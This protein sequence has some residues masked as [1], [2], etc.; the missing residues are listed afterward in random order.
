MATSWSHPL[1]DHAWIPLRGRGEQVDGWCAY[2]NLSAAESLDIEQKLSAAM[3][4]SLG[5]TTP[6]SGQEHGD[7]AQRFSESY[8]RHRIESNQFMS[9]CEPVRVHSL[10]DDFLSTLQQ[11]VTDPFP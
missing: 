5:S 7:A 11:E 8:I 3:L 2:H 4:E 10:A 9:F 6:F 1:P